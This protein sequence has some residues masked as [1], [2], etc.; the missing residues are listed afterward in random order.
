MIFETLFAVTSAALSALQFDLRLIADF[1][2]L[3]IDILYDLLPSD[4]PR[5]ESEDML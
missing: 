5:I 2:L 1:S 3:S 4:S